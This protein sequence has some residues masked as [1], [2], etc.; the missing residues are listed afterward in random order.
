M[1][2]TTQIP[3]RLGGRSYKVLVG[4]GNLRGLGPGVRLVHDGAE[5]LILSNTRVF[6][7]YGRTTEESLRRA[8]FTTV[9]RVLVPDG[10]R[11]KSLET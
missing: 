11:Y 7:L 9:E 2:G 10:E 5:A 4:W 8:G 3:V 1:P 6:G